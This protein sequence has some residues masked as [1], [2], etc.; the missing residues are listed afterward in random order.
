MR[1]FFSLIFKNLQTQPMIK[2][3]CFYLL[4]LSPLIT[5]AQQ[6]PQ[7]I[8]ANAQKDSIIIHQYYHEIKENKSGD[9]QGSIKQKIQ[10]NR[11]NN[12]DYC[13]AK[14]LFIKAFDDFYS[15]G[16]QDT[17]SINESILFAKKNNYVSIFAEAQ[18]FKSVRLFEQQSYEKAFW[19]FNEI[20]KMVDENP[21]IKIVSDYAIW[22]S[23]AVCYFKFED[24][25]K[26]KNLLLTKVNYK[27][28]EDAYFYFQVNNTI[29]M[30]YE[31]LKNQDSARYF[32]NKGLQI[33]VDTKDSARIGVSIGNLGKLFAVDKNFNNAIPNLLLDI[34]LS[35]KYLDTSNAVTSTLFLMD[36]YKQQKN[37]SAVNALLQNIDTWI[38]TNGNPM[39]LIN[40]F[41]QK[42]I[43][44][45]ELQNYK[46]AYRFLDSSVFY[47][48][49][50]KQLVDSKILIK[51]QSQNFD[52]IK[53]YEQKLQIA[54]EKRVALIRYFSISLFALAML[55]LLLFVNR[56]LI[57]QK[58]KAQET[59]AK[60]KLLL[61]EKQSL[62]L[63]LNTAKQNLE[64]FT[65][66]IVSKN[67]LIDEFTAELET[68]KSQLSTTSNL[69][70]VE[71]KTQ[72]L[73]DSQILTEAGWQNFKQL[74]ES[75]YK[76]FFQKVSAIY[77]ELT[78]SEIRFLAI[79]KL[80]ITT[81][82][83]ANMLGISVE[84]VTKTKYRINKKYQDQSI[85]NPIEW[86]N[87]F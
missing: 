24:Y 59:L 63:E 40:Y 29:G 18:N 67:K 26:A 1:T 45:Y 58:N 47:T 13:V 6:S 46:D 20:Q 44:A 69:S 27:K 21:G 19:G 15:A 50:E 16:N 55:A 4:I 57:K 66:R 72:L 32:F 33:G 62:D 48:Q 37:N 56:H 86:T 7:Q 80:N 41:A 42:S 3:V 79:S 54:K 87:A 17:I 5:T 9:R 12:E 22:H 39:Q 23:I 35:K 11:K 38:I 43:C 53:K 10:E 60:N 70:N 81:K 83:T 2:I 68:L 30:C 49:K 73:I 82:E 31:K 25:E 34:R 64:E 76:G 84:S 65:N 51:A 75:V 28:I 74:F 14:W 61:L 71:Q 36:I 78:T 85:L 52:R 77:P 8:L